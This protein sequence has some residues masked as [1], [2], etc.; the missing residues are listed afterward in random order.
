MAGSALPGS[1]RGLT[2]K[3]SIVGSL[4]E[5]DDASC[6][7]HR[8]QTLDHGRTG[9]EKVLQIPVGAEPDRVPTVLTGIAELHDDTLV[10]AVV[11]G[12]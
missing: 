8:A 10:D 11:P 12:R 9:P 2:G 5:G 3:G 6:V 4:L 7:A 1:A